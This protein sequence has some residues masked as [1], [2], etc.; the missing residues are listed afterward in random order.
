MLD[1]ALNRRAPKASRG[2]KTFQVLQVI[3]KTFG[4]HQTVRPDKH[5]IRRHPPLI[6]RNNIRRRDNGY[7][8]DL[9]AKDELPVF[10]IIRD[11]T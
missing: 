11:Q 10:R 4:L 9:V 8:L 7:A 5:S 3:Y 2:E 1:I 6:F